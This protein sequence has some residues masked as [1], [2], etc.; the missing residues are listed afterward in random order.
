VSAVFARTGAQ[1]IAPLA[2]EALVAI[3]TAVRLVLQH[4]AH[5]GVAGVDAKKL[6]ERY[7]PYEQRT[8]RGRRS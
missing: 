2:G 3:G 7:E 6:F 5:V 1:F 8:N 4:A